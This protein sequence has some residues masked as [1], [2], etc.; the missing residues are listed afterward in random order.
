MSAQDLPAGTLVGGDF[1]VVETLARGGM[2]VVYVAEQESTRKRRALKVMSPQPGDLETLRKRFEQEAYVSS[3][4]ESDHVVEVI[5]AGVDAA[6]TMPW[7]A[8]EM[9]EGEDLEN[10]LTNV[11]PLDWTDTWNMVGELCHALEAAHKLGLIHRDLKPSNVYLAKSRR[12]GIERVVKIL[13]FGIAKRMSDAGKT[14]GAL[15]TPLY[16]APEQTATGSNFSPATDVW[17]LGLLVFETLVGIPFW[18]SASQDGAIA[19]LLREVVLEAIPPA[20]ERAAFF[21][22]AEK[23]PPRFDAWFARC[24]VRDPQAR[25]RDAGEAYRALARVFSEVTG[26]NERVIPPPSTRLPR[27]PASAGEPTPRSTPRE[28]LQART[29]PAFE[30][31]TSPVPPRSRTGVLVAGIATGVAVVSVAIAVVFVVGISGPS[32]QAG[33]AMPARD[34]APESAAPSASAPSSGPQVVPSVIASADGPAPLVSPS[35]PVPAPSASASGWS[36]PRTTPAEPK[37]SAPASPPAAPPP[38]IPPAPPKPPPAQPDPV[39]L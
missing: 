26:L 20:S 11:G 10:H 36:P 19:A 27:A 38:R 16:M 25:F 28:A 34:P 2:G 35:S 37:T 5:G 32:K 14:T 21:G 39:I 13:D 1:R 29:Q 9:L 8:M 23:L 22:K 15:G 6:T 33:S 17:A 3:Q 30:K 12:P 31:S 18:K 7:I 24:V 4:I